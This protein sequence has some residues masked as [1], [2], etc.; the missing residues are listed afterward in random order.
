MFRVQ[1]VVLLPQAM[2]AQQVEKSLVATL[3][4]LTVQ[5]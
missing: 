2:Q 4:I 1:A 5:Q 3:I